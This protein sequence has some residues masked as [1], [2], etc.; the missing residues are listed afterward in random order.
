MTPL[1]KEVIQSIYSALSRLFS[2]VRSAY[3]VLSCRS[4]Q[5]QYIEWLDDKITRERQGKI[6]Q[7]AHAHEEVCQPQIQSLD[8]ADDAS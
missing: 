7:C 6:E 8:M 1:Q 2:L 4:P 5:F 3:N